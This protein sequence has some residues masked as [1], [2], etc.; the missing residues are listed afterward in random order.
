MNSPLASVARLEAAYRRWWATAVVPSLPP[1]LPM[2][3]RREHVII[4]GAAA[5]AAPNGIALPTLYSRLGVMNTRSALTGVVNDLVYGKY[6]RRTKDS[7]NPGDRRVVTIDVPEEARHA[8]AEILQIVAVAER[9]LRMAGINPEAFDAATA[10]L[11][12]FAA[13]GPIPGN[14]RPRPGLPDK[15]R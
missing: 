3:W 5:A 7:S 10:Q 8:V 15:L 1:T 11:R 12:R 6:L 2:A 14:R 4:L 9:Q 13:H